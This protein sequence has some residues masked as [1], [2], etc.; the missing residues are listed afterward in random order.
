MTLSYYFLFIALTALGIDSFK[1]WIWLSALGLAGTA[2][3]V[4]LIHL[5]SGFFEHFLV[6]TFLMMLG[7]VIVLRREM[8]PSHDGAPISGLALGQTGQNVDTW[9][10]AAGYLNATLAALMVSVTGSVQESYLGIIV[11][12]LLLAAA[13]FWMAPAVAL[14]DFAAAPAL[15]FVLFLAAQPMMNGALYEA[16]LESSNRPPET[17]PPGMIWHLLLVGLLGGVIAF[18]RLRSANNDQIAL[19]WSLGGGAF[20]AAT[21]LSLEFLWDPT[22]IYEPFTWA[23]MVLGAAAVMTLLTERVAR[24]GHLP[25]PLLHAS[26]FGSA[27]VSLI[28]LSLFLLLTKSALTVALAVQ[29]L[30]LVLLDRR[31]GL[32]ALRVFVYIGAAVISYRVVADPG[33]WWAIR[34]QVGIFDVVLGYGATGLVLYAAWLAAD[35]KLTRVKTTLEATLWIVGASLAFVLLERFLPGRGLDTH[36]GVG[37]LVAVWLV[38]FFAQVRQIPGSGWF[39]GAIRVVLA[40]IVGLL[41][42]VCL[43]ALYVFVNPLSSR[44]ELIGGIPFFSTLA[45]AYLPSAVVF[46]LAAWKI[47][48]RPWARIGSASA[49]AI[50]ALTY[51]GLSIRHFWQGPDI[52]SGAVSDAELYSYTI[53]LILLSVGTL[54]VAFWLRAVWLRKLA[55]IGVGVAIAK[56][57]L[58][59]MS[60][61]TGLVRVFSFMGLGLSLL[62][63]T[64][65]S[66]KMADQW[67]RAEPKE[68]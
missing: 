46:A 15:G 44:S 20:V 57:F 55:M 54:I 32:P 49:A 22:Q 43:L 66:R 61:L 34:D 38:V 19:V 37:M 28:G 12:M 40:G 31:T 53:A 35:A 1:R 29:I 39:E 27:S 50:L 2:A 68:S 3:S 4:W 52:S 24:M 25:A 45:L 11:V 47:D 36:W 7:T 9:I 41:V 60:G 33:V 58:I 56:V 21:V 65:L 23:A 62:G 5:S 48:M 16:F 30:A 6:V 42:A 13:A 51:V 64:W 18:W 17:A 10:A 26:F 63:L 67:D 59:D 8:T 14:S